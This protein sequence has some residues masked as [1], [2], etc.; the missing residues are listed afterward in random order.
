MDIILYELEYN[1]YLA[2]KKFLDELASISVQYNGIL[3]ESNM[4]VVQE[5]TIESFLKYIRTIMAN[6]QNTYNKF[7]TNVNNGIWSEIKEKHGKIL[8]EDHKLIVSGVKEDEPGVPRFDSVENFIKIK[9]APFSEPMINKYSSKLEAIKGLYSYFDSAQDDKNDTLRA[10]INKNCYTKINQNYI[11]TQDQIKEYVAFLDN[12]KNRSNDIANDMKIINSSE[13]SIETVIKQSMESSG[14]QVTATQTT[15]TT[16]QT[17]TTEA[18]IES[19]LES[20]MDAVL[21]EIEF[22][23]SSSA[24]KNE[25]GKP[26]ADMNKFV[27]SYFGAITTVLSLKMKTLDSVR[28][29]SLNICRNYIKKGINDNKISNPDVDKM[30][31]VPEEDNKAGATQLE[32]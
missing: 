4:Q 23:T 11:I 31:K 14:E 3:N 20:A 18:F 32:V 19:V 27:T 6:I 15:Q 9:P 22:D 24:G 2:E 26:N 25:D 7:K 10:I 12:Y 17:N 1:N 21:N 8:S 5:I 16:Q 30:K 29:L 13:R 28:R